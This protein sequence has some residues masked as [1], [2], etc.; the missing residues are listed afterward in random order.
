MSENKDLDE[1]S[2]KLQEQIIE[3]YRNYYTDKVIELWKNPKH[4]G[5]LPH[6]DGHAKVKGSCGDTMEIFI[7]VKD[8]IITESTFT[9]DGCGATIACGST[10]ADLVKGKTFTKALGLVNAK[11]VLK[12][13]GGLPKE[14]LHCA[15]L[16]SEAVRRALAD[17]LYHKK[18]SWKK[19]YRK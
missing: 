18:N 19:H 17:Y 12:R 7:K 8:D 10:A 13:L 11:Q 2:R 4:M 6:P 3:Q 9:S 15:D 5:E 1:F 16:A 14:H